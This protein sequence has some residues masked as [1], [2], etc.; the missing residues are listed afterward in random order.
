MKS[1][2][3]NHCPCGSGRKYRN[4]CLP[5][6]DARCR[7]DPPSSTRD[8]LTKLLTFAF[9]PA[10]D[11]DHSVA[12]IV[13]WGT[14]IRDASSV[15]LQWLLDSEDAKIEYNSW[16]VFDWEVENTGTVAGAVPR[17]GARAR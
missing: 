15:E 16:F 14:R 3:R 8:A 17:G 1:A 9:Q 11:S 7:A 5:G 12:E 2:G 6:D 10:F 4:C 13:F